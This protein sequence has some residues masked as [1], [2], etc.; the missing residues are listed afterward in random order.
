[1]TQFWKEEKWGYN[2]HEQNEQNLLFWL[3]PPPIPLISTIM[4]NV[5]YTFSTFAQKSYR[6]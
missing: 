5:F 4:H 2:I 6:G 3:D 1:M